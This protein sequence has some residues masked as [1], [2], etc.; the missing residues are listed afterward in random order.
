[1]KTKKT[2]NIRHGD[3]ALVKVDKLPTGLTKA[4]TNVLM[5]GSHNNDHSVTNCDVYFKNEDRFV[6]GY[7][8]ANKGAELLHIDHGKGKKNQIKKAPLPVGVYQM[9]KQHEET[10]Q[11]LTPI[12]D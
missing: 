2:D 9:R 3:L 8:K 10:H 1:M 12:I 4:K 11:G 7:L 5:T 6:F